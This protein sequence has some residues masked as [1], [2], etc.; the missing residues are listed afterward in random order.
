LTQRRLSRHGAHATDSR[1]R[2]SRMLTGPLS[3]R[4]VTSTSRSPRSPIISS[5]CPRNSRSTPTS[6]ARRSTRRSRSPVAGCFA[7]SR[8]SSERAHWTKVLPGERHQGRRR[9]QW[10]SGAGFVDG[11]VALFTQFC[12][13]SQWG[14]PLTWAQS[15]TTPTSVTRIC[16]RYL[17]PSLTALWNRSRRSSPSCMLRAKL[18]EEASTARSIDSLE[19]RERSEISHGYCLADL[20]Y[21]VGMGLLIGCAADVRDRKNQDSRKLP[22]K[23]VLNT[24]ARHS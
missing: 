4:A 2:A 6:S 11:L 19:G 18:L 1:A 14:P 17:V 20:T 24:L 9:R 22:T 5:S 7:S 21:T 13:G 16:A 23:T 15:L 12:R 3:S 8:R 10:Q